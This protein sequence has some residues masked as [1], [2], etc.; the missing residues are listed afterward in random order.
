MRAAWDGRPGV[1][2][3][4]VPENVINGE[5][6]PLGLPAPERYRRSAP[7]APDPEQVK[8]AAEMLAGAALPMIQAGSG[9]IHAQAYAELAEL[10]ELLEAPVTTS[11]GARECSARTRPWPGPW[12]TSR[13]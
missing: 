6:K 8:Q 7:L 10:A 4:D 12:C 13:R 5:C 9:V 1:V 11:W 3:L 2:H